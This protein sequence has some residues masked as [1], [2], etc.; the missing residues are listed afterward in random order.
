M[1]KRDF[2]KAGLVAGM[3]AGLSSPSMAMGKSDKRKG[4][5]GFLLLHGSWHGAWA[6]TDIIKYLNQAGYP[7][8]AIDLPGHGLDAVL[9]KSFAK[10][11]L[12]KAAFATEPSALAGYSIIDYR[13]AVI[14]AAE[15]ARQSGIKKLIAVGHSMGG[16]PLTFAAAKRPSLFS[17]LVYIAAL[18]PTKDKPAGAYLG[19]P[20]QAQNSKLG[21]AIMAD[22]AVIGALR[23][24]PRA[25][26]TA[27]L[28]SFKQALA[29]DVD[30]K[31]LGAV[32]HLLTPDAPVSIYGE[33]AEFSKGFGRLPKRYIRAVHDETVLPSTAQAIVNDLNANWPNQTT[34]MVDIASSHEVMFAQARLLSDLLI[35]AAEQE[36]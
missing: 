8:M 16:V 10:R 34:E 7:A 9:P 13:L 15:Q 17:K 21:P 24:D 35:E 31:L 12:D 1:K 23:I 5:T 28:D 25:T 19:L 26:D 22:P 6:W 36:K 27:Y 29:A 18:L 32:M 2:L 20:D 33:V 11:P 4:K 30:D 3:A 14:E